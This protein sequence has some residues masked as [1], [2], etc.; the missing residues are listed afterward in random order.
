MQ[1]RTPLDMSSEDR[2]PLAFA[3]AQS[4]KKHPAQGDPRC[5]PKRPRACLPAD[6][7]KRRAQFNFLL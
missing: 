2:S 6:R 4:E 3:N 1:I 5:K 7:Q